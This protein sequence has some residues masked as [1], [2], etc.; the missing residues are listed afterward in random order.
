MRRVWTTLAPLLVLLPLPGSL[1]CRAEGVTFESLSAEGAGSKSLR[2]G[3]KLAGEFFKW[4][5]EAE[6]RKPNAAAKKVAAMKSFRDWLDGTKDSAGQDLRKF[7]GVVI[8]VLDRGR[9]SSL[10]TPTKGK[11]VYSSVETPGVSRGRFEYT[12]LVPKNYNQKND[13]RTPIVIALH[14]RVIDVRHPAFRGNTK[15][16]TE[17][18]RQV[19]HDYYLGNVLGDEYLVVAPTGTPNGFNYKVSQADERQYEERQ[20]LF[21]ALGH[22]LSA[23]RSDWHRVW[24][25]LQGS[26][27]RLA[28]EQGLIFTGI[29]LRDRED[30]R[31]P[32]L[33]PE[34]AFMLENLNGMPLIYVADEKTWGELGSVVSDWLT[35]VYTKAGKLENLLVFKVPRDATGALQ[36]DPQKVAEFMAKHKSPVARTDIQWRFFNPDMAAPPPHELIRAMYNYDVSDAAR[37]QPLEAKAGGLHLRVMRETFT[38]AEGKAMPQNVIHLDISEAEAIRL[39]LSDGFVDLDLPVTVVVN[40]KVVQ[41]KV[42]IERNWE[43]FEQLVLPRRFFMLPFV[44]ELEFEFGY[45]PRFSPPPPPAPP[46]EGG[47]EKPPEPPGGEAGDKPPPPGEADRG[48]AVREPDRDH[49]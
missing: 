46:A 20:A 11:L 44:A 42:K 13:T 14:G 8:E 6:A 19:V 48:G 10:A 7:P 27:L 3:I 24:L 36:A 30:D 38:D 22:A 18:S 25:D 33:P 9:A 37:K 29:V 23:Y 43:L 28:C 47:G 41:D 21:L 34:E 15:I 39:R 5:A 32:F 1:E 2:E 17:R 45:K 12:T 16:F 31:K 40:G 35:K 4:E 49:P 26:A